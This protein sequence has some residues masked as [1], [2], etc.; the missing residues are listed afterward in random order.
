MYYNIIYN[1]IYICR[2]FSLKKLYD[3]IFDKPCILLKINLEKLNVIIFIKIINLLDYIN[4]LSIN[5]PIK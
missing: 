3:K 5:S 4:Y 2:S 1:F